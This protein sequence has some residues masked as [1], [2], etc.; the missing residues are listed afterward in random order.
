MRGAQTDVCVRLR[1]VAGM[2]AGR[3]EV[4]TMTALTTRLL[5]LWVRLVFVVML[6]FLIL[7][8][9]SVGYMCSVKCVL[10]SRMFRR[11][12]VSNGREMSCRLLSRG[13]TK[14]KVVWLLTGITLRL[15]LT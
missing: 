9:I 1:A 14:Q 15:G 3:F 11:L 2:T 12:V 5:G 10:V 4:I 8:K 6:L 13:F 7:A